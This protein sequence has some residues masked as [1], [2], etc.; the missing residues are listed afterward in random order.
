[1]SLVRPGERLFIV[2]GIA[3]VAA[4]RGLRDDAATLRDGDG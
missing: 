2:K 4:S 1:M 3:R